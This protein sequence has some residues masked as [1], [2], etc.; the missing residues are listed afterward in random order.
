M[1]GNQG[2]GARAVAFGDPV[3]A[4]AIW[5]R[6]LHHAVTLNIRG[7]SYRLVEKLEA[8]LLRAEETPA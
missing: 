5:D 8:G 1:A 4:T 6:G 7:N 2:F 3:I